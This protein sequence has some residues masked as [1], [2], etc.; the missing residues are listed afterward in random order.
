MTD[1]YRTPPGDAV[2]HP[3]GWARVGGVEVT[4]MPMLDR[5]TGL[6]A[7]LSYAELEEVAEREGGRLV[8]MDTLLDVWDVGVRLVPVTLVARQ[9]DTRHMRGRAFCER[10]D[11]AVRAQ[12]EALGWDGHSPVANVGKQ[13]IRGAS[14]GKARNG[15]WFKKDGIAIQ[16][17]GPGSEHHDR[18]Y[19]DYSQL[20]TIEREPVTPLPRLTEDSM[21]PDTERTP[22]RP[23]AFVQARNFTPGRRACIGLVVLHSAEA[24]ERNDTAERLA[25]WA[26]GPQAA[27]SSWHYAVDADSVVQSVR[28]ADTA[29][30]APGANH[31]GIGIEHAGYAKQTSDDWSDPYSSAM[32]E[33]SAV[34]VSGICARHAIP[35][36][37]VDASGLVRGERGITT[38][39]EVSK[40][41]KKSTH[42]DPGKGFPLDAFLDMVRAVP[43]GGGGA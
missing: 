27:R 15:G 3:S 39:A 5:L 33:R 38:H 12:L 18:N 29:W 4:C 13:W 16:P 41:F 1:V 9:D 8:S 21:P 19:S 24:I 6:F 26:A 10:H 2:L 43:A 11:A 40:A 35:L 31:N 42:T 17:G 25:A 23:I 30:H 7:R 34:L 32:L 14:A 37:F 36:A 28:E 22:I 20:A